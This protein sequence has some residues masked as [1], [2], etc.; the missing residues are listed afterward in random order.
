MDGNDLC[1]MFFMLEEIILKQNQGMTQTVEI[2]NLKCG[3]CE[4]TI[5]KNL[6]KFEFVRNLEVDVQKGTVSLDALPPDYLVFVKRVL[7]NMG[8]PVVE[9]G[10]SVGKK[11]KSYVSCALGRMNT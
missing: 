7:S 1:H 8:Y 5:R 3:G 9:D 11:V 4:N 6:N 10:N 2:Q